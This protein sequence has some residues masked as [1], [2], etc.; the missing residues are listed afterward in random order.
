MLV[1]SGG[2]PT[3]LRYGTV[4]D[5]E[6]FNAGGFIKLK[7]ISQRMLTNSIQRHMPHLSSNLDS[8]VALPPYR[9]APPRQVTG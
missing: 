8:R 9:V 1:R 3:C 2:D 5:D 4:Q 6:A 7:R